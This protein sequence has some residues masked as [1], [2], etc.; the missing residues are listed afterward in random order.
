MSDTTEVNT[1]GVTA[2]A[3]E[4]LAN[5]EPGQPTIHKVLSFTDIIA[6]DDIETREVSIPAWNGSIIVKVFTKAEQQQIR[7]DMAAASTSGDKV[8]ADAFE[9]YVIL[10]GLKEPAL[11]AEQYT[12]LMEKSSIAMQQLLDAILNING[13]TE[14]SQKKEEASFQG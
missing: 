12:L 4:M 8:D 7:R 9:K 5:N 3:A 10:T 1:E 14:E 6:A 13:L 11:S 2:L